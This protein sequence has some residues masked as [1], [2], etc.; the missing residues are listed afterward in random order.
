[1]PPP[2]SQSNEN[3]PCTFAVKLRGLKDV[4]V[5]SVVTSLLTSD[6]A[7]HPGAEE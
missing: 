1:M 2:D 5:N 7:A 4:T 3:S 6:A